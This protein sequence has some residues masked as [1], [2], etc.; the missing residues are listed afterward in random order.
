ML[1]ASTIDEVTELIDTGISAMAALEADYS[2]IT[3]PPAKSELHEQQ[4]RILAYPIDLYS[5]MADALEDP[6]ELLQLFE[7]ISDFVGRAPELSAKVSG[8]LADYFEG[9]A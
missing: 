9:L 2:A 4:L 8:K 7:E 6:T 3:P 5:L 1:V